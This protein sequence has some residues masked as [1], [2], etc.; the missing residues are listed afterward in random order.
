MYVSGNT[1]SW[2][3]LGVADVLLLWLVFSETGSTIAVAAVGLAQA[4]PPI[5][6]GFF[7]GVL[8]DRYSRRR[9]LLL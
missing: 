8:A 9:L 5:G 7:A 1:A 2:A 4:V 6:V 3:G